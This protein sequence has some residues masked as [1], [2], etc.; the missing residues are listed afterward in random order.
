M[1]GTAAT[2]AAAQ[3]LAHSE[4]ERAENLMIVD[5]LRND[6]ARIATHIQVP[7]LFTVHTLSTLL[8]MTSTITGQVRDGLGLEAIF[9][10]LFPCGSI[11]GAPKIASMRAIKALETTPRGPYCGA[12]GLVEPGGSAT[13]SVGIR[14]VSVMGSQALCGIGSGI[15]WDSTPTQEYAEGEIKRRFLWRATA[16]FDLLETLKLEEG[17]YWLLTRHLARLQRS[18]AHF[19]FPYT[20]DSLNARLEA[21]AQAYPQGAYR[22]RLLLSRNGEIK[23]EIFVLEPILAPLR[24]IL[25]QNPIKN[26]EFLRYKTTHR[27][28]YE[29]FLPA[30]PHVFDTILYNEKG[31]VTEFTRGNIALQIEGQLVT[32]PEVCGLLPGTLREDMLEKH[33]LKERVIRIEDLPRATAM[34]FLNAVRGKVEVLREED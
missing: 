9:A 6:L 17:H 23:T 7:D 14:C 2:E 11:T 13:F 34:Y 27:A 16:T 25:A 10:A 30:N 18:A 5:L 28:I 4:K 12:F 15:T 26:D 21:L 22:V 24:V 19:G 1:K 33:I 3:D 32:P 20:R 29:P 8:Q 31:E